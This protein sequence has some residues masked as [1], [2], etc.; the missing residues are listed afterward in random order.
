MTSYISVSICTEG[1]FHVCSLSIGTESYAKKKKKRKKD[2]ARK[3][4]LADVVAIMIPA[5]FQHLY[6]AKI[7]K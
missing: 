4:K 6:I 3:D 2:G 7:E 5:R 1:M